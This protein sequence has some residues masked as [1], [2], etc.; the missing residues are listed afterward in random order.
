MKHRNLE[1][2]QSKGWTEDRS[3]RCTKYLVLSKPGVDYHY[4]LGGSGAVRRGRTVGNS[5]SIKLKIGDA[6]TGPDALLTEL[7]ESLDLMVANADLG[8]LVRWRVEADCLDLRQLAH[9]EL[10]R[11]GCVEEAVM[12]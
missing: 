1:Y 12:A 2:L 11:R 10:H 9:A 7:R 5:I 6:Y 4:Y 3:T 8:T